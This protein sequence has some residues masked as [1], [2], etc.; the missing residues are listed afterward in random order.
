[1]GN[2]VMEAFG[3]SNIYCSLD[4]LGADVAMVDGQS[5]HPQRYPLWG[6]LSDGQ[7]QRVVG[8]A[9]LLIDLELLWGWQKGRLVFQPMYLLQ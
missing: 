8:A 4:P 3:L 6:N 1:M 7:T 5:H 9:D 2:E